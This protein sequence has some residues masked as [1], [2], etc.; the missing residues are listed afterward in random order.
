MG[1]NVV[2]GDPRRQLVAFGSCL[3]ADSLVWVTRT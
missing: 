2:P 3:W 1:V